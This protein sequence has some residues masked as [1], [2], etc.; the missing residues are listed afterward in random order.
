MFLKTNLIAKFL[1]NF[2]FPEV[3]LDSD[4]KAVVV[5]VK[6]KIKVV[7]VQSCVAPVEK[8]LCVVSK[9]LHIHHEVICP[10]SIPYPS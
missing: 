9:L 6:T 5:Q 3:P 10:S 8:W 2:C 4:G 1:E 7:K